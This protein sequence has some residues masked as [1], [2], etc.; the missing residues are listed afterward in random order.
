MSIFAMIV[1]RSLNMEM[2]LMKAP[3]ED[4]AKKIKSDF[5]WLTKEKLTYLVEHRPEILYHLQP[6]DIREKNFLSILKNE[7]LLFKLADNLKGSL[8]WQ[9]LIFQAIPQPLSPMI[10][11]HY[12]VLLNFLDESQ[13]SDMGK[14]WV[15]KTNSKDFIPS[16]LVKY[17]SEKQLI[18]LFKNR[19]HVDFNEVPNDLKTVSV[20]KTYFENDGK[21]VIEKLY[22]KL[23]QE[24]QDNPQ[25]ALLACQ[26]NKQFYKQ[27]SF[28]AKCEEKVISYVTQN[29]IYSG[30]DTVADSVD[31]TAINAGDIPI[32]G[33]RKIN[34]SYLIKNMLS[35]Q[36]GLAQDHQ[37]QEKWF[38]FKNSQEFMEY[39]DYFPEKIKSSIEKE[40][41]NYSPYDKAVA[42]MHNL[43][44]V[45]SIL[46]KKNIEQSFE[47]LYFYQN[48]GDFDKAVKNLK[49][50]QLVKQYPDEIIDKYLEKFKKGQHQEM[51]QV[52]KLA[53]WFFKQDASYEEYACKIMS[54]VLEKNPDIL[55]SNLSY[56]YNIEDNTLR[57]KS[58]I[59][60]EYMDNHKTKKMKI[61]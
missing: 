1:L 44:L 18:N 46:D 4:V 8:E 48:N 26:K 51:G 60:Y 45:D 54:Q 5:S 56:L 20:C 30:C 24:I 42:L 12:G 29:I 9:P 19:G 3:V 7:N 13:Y 27:L 32:E 55:D 52:L 10:F 39:L 40:I 2:V 23:P 47:V 22:K 49:L 41:L 16:S 35:Q 11:K 50:T 33:L 14:Q 25:I 6:Q 37:I 61:K 15:E 58:T 43:S 59:I 28:K 53:S 17:L 31:K 57:K 38:T 34:S 36:K 21:Y